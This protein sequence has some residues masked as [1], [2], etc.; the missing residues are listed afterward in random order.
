MRTWM[1]GDGIELGD[2]SGEEAPS[3]FRVELGDEDESSLRKSVA[4]TCPKD[5]IA[6]EV[7]SC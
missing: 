3:A 4:D 7:R 2:E 5:S 1:V 6:G